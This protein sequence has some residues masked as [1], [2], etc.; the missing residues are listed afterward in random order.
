M[1]NAISRYPNELPF[2][3]IAVI[4]IAKLTADKETA[5]SILIFT[6]TN[7]QFQ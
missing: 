4:H 3:N 1:Q 5:V 2:T 7:R 6:V